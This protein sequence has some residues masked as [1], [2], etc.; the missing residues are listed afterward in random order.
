MSTKAEIVATIDS[1]KSELERAVAQLGAM[2]DLDWGTVRCAAHTLGN[3]LN[4]TNAY[5]ELLKMALAD[6]PDA[7]V[8][9][10]LQGLE[11]TLELMIYVSRQLTNTSAASEV[12][13]LPEV[14]DLARQ[15]KGATWF[16]ENMAYHK[17]LQFLCDASAP[18][19]VWA[20]RIAMAAVLDNLISNAVK[21]SPPGKRVWVQVCNEPGHAVCTVKDE[22]PGLTIEDQ[23]RLFQKGVRL[24]ATPTGGE[25]SSGFGLFIAKRLVERMGGSLWVETAPGQG[26]Q[27]SFR[28][29]ASKEESP[30][31]APRCCP[32]P[33]QEA[34]SE[35]VHLGKIR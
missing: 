25:S 18:V 34:E 1:A 20:D 13:L 14:V 31:V 30:Q 21:Y 24:S 10:W 11:R 15:A 16:Y 12:P 5:I 23:G 28:L 26:C 3:Y 6:H 33:D 8:A 32:K 17:N 27:F 9:S 35:D 2:P 29:P 22:G 4:I 7:E 19:P